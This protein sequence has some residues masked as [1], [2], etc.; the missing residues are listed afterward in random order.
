MAFSDILPKNSESRAIAI[1]IKLLKKKAPH[2]KWVISFAD[3]CQCW[4]WTIY[5]ASGFELTSVKE[6]WSLVKMPDWQILHNLYITAHRPD[7]INDMKKW[8]VINWFMLRYVIHLKPNLTRNYEILPY[9]KIEEMWA[10][11]YKW[12]K[13]EV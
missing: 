1:S 13:Q 10:K 12:I 2:L 6:N 9:S 5:R 11:M 8:E 7:L 4:D 3:W